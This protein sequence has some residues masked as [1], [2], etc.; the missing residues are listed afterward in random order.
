MSIHLLVPVGSVTKVLTRL[1]VIFGPLSAIVVAK[2]DRERDSYKKRN[3][4]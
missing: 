1:A 3:K 2:K 4:H